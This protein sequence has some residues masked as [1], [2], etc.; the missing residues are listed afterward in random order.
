VAREVLDQAPVT[1]LAFDGFEPHDLPGSL[2]RLVTFNRGSAKSHSGIYRDL[3][4]RRRP[5]EVG[6]LDL[7][8][9]PLTSYT[10]AL[11]RAI[12][13]GDRTCEVANLDL[14]AALERLE[15]LGRPVNAVVAALPAPDRAP[16][17]PLHGVAVAV[18]D[19]MDVAGL[20]RGNGNPEDMAG[21][22]SQ[23]DAPVVG[24]LR[25]AGA[26]VF[27]LASLLEYAAG[28]PHPDLPEARNPVRPDR[29]A[30]GSSGGSAALVAAGVCSV[31]LG[32]DTGGS[33]RI[34]A[35]YCGVVGFKPSHGL[36]AEEGV[37]ALSPSL[38]HVGLI[39]ATV[40]D[41]LDVLPVIADVGDTDESATEETATDE[42]ATGRGAVRL[43][44]LEDQL[45]DPR[46]HPEIAA[47]TRAALARLADAGF[48]Q[49]PRDGAVLAE[50]DG[51]LEPILMVEAWQIHADT[52][53]EHP[54]HFGEPTR[55]L[56]AAAE[57]A[58]A[59][60]RETALARR[61]ELRPAVEALFA[62]VDALVGPVVPYAAPE[63]TPPIDTPE[64]EIEGIFTGPY[65]VTGQPAVTVPCGTTADGLPVGLQL[66][67]PLGQDVALLRLAAAV[68]AAL[69]T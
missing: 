59:A 2:A 35:A 45:A 56:F 3:M 46:L 40:Q 7:L 37:T 61:D 23:T 27:A 60:A 63:L 57:H 21:P 53:R 52:V 55:R 33:I 41:C 30:G 68:E 65:N 66:A 17:G 44:V 69:G 26:D 47:V 42:R 38:D 51:L 24:R 10:A 19:L 14:L 39:T 54:E 32:T 4:V 18:K 25:A 58:E 62:G 16:D 50:A 22:P 34:P 31:A 11:I 15:R 12:E 13:R 28:A 48:A 67:A 9:G 5:T 20:P 29:T 49:E 6:E 1:P 36:V 43:G 64:G 8:A